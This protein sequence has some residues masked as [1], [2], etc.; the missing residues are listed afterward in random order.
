MR[1]AVD[2]QVE[3]ALSQ[4]TCRRFAQSRAAVSGGVRAARV[5][6]ARRQPAPE[7]RM[8]PAKKPDGETIAQQAADRAVPT[9]LASAQ[10]VAMLDARAPAGQIAL[11][12]IETE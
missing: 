11:P 4:P 6:A 1:V 8:H 7:V 2:Q 12:R 9:V 3:I 10:A 5:R